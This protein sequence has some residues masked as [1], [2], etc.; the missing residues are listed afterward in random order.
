MP[1][2]S[3][4]STVLEVRISIKHIAPPIWRLVLVR[5]TA[6]LDDLHTVIQEAFG[7]QNYHLYNFTHGDRKF[8]WPG[9]DLGF[10]DSTRMTLQR[11]GLT[12]GDT[13][14][15]WYDFGDDWHHEV[16]IIAARRAD[17][18]ALYPRCVDG[19]RAGPPED[20]GG[21]P[22]YGELLAILADP[23]HERFAEMRA[24]AGAHFQPETFDL[25]A[26]NRILELAFR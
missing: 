20:C 4:P 16:S 8:G 5:S 22:G 7:W 24:W 9:G 18:E 19:A 23:T 14:E 6:S 10:E 11:L 17:P 21:P 26:T 2:K 13:I 3:R 12:T 15:Y 25:R 1:A